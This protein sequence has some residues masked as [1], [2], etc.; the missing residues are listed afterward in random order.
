VKEE[1]KRVIMAKVGLDGHDRG[2]AVVSMWLRDGGMEVIYLGRYQTVDKVVKA[3]IEEDADIIGLSFLG[4]EHLY[5]SPQMLKTM[6]E[7]GVKARLI[8]GGII[9]RDDIPKLKEM[10][11]YAVFPAAISMQKIVE[12]VTQLER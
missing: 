7:R 10:G 11:V 3:A 9:P 5:Y 12:C 6:K 2:L 4:G 8:V 1:K